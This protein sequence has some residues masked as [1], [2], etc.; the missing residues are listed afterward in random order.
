MRDVHIHFLHG[1]PIGYNMEFFEGFIK[2]AQE[3]GLDLSHPLMSAPELV[4]IM[5]Q[6]RSER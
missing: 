4:R 2:V 6:A 1:N 5:R 3:A